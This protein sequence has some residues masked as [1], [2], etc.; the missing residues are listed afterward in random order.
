[1]A[2]NTDQNEA[3]IDFNVYLAGVGLQQAFIIFCPFRFQVS[4]SCEKRGRDPTH[5]Y[6]LESVLYVLYA[7]LLLITV[8]LKRP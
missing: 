6:K 5:Y 4:P 7:V 1:M 3:A 8:N 2:I